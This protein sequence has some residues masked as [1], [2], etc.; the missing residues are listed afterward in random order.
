MLTYTEDPKLGTAEITISGR[1]ATD[2]FHAVAERLEKLIA[3]HGQARVLEHIQSFEGMDAAA[4]WEDIKFSLRHLN[5]ISRCAVVTEEHWVNL[6]SELIQPFIKCE[7]QH[8]EP[9]EI[10]AARAWLAW[11]EGSADV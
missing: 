5:D 1:V 7:V 3:T 6:W 11:P 10:E 4:F 9:S 2:E 8:F